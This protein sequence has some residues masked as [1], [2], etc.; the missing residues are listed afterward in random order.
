MES[1]L[2]LLS[3]ISKGA[4]SNAEKNKGKR[5]TMQAK[6]NG[7]EVAETQGRN[8]IQDEVGEIAETRWR[9]KRKTQKTPWSEAGTEISIKELSRS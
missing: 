1:G 5:N 3:R 8:K 6:S 4:A 2:A 7:E 9:N